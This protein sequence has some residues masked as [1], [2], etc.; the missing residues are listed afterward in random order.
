MSAYPGQ[1]RSPTEGF[2]SVQFSSV[3]QSCPTLCKPMNHS[4]P[5]LPVHHQFPEFT[6][7]HVHQVGDAI[8]SSHPLSSPSPP[9]PNPSEYQGLFQW[10]NSSHEVAKVLEL[11][12]SVSLIT[13]LSVVNFLCLSTCP[14]LSWYNVSQI[15]SKLTY[16]FTQ[17]VAQ[18]ATLEELFSKFSLTY[19]CRTIICLLHM[20][21]CV[22][23]CVK[24]PQEFRW[25]RM[26]VTIIMHLAYKRWPGMYQ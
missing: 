20:C 18:N 2:T 24:F 4:T 10:V 16:F 1:S 13:V 19:T 12:G 22:G 25:T 26:L 8:Q 15:H 7:T 6:Q 21:V 23:V 9:T 17:V 3:T 5:G 14:H 11:G